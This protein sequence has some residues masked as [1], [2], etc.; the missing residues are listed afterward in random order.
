M[1]GVRRRR[2][3]L[4]AGVASAALVLAATGSAMAASPSPSPTSPRPAPSSSP[5]PAAASPVIAPV[6][7]P[8]SHVLPATTGQVV[9]SPPPDTAAL[10]AA[11]LRALGVTAVGSAVG[12]SVLDVATGKPL[13][14]QAASTALLPASTL[15]VLTAVAVLRGWG[16]QARVRT[17]VVAGAKGQIVLVG[18]GDAT[19]SRTAKPTWPAGMD[20]RPASLTELADATAKAL[21]A[22]GLATVSVAVDDSYFTGP[23]SAPGWPTAYTASG[24]IAPVTALS[25][26]QGRSGPAVGASARVKDPALAAGTTFADLLKARGIKVTG[27]LVRTKAGP[28]AHELAA[29]QSPPMSDLVERMLT[30]S[31]D[32]LAEAL[33]HLAGAKLGGSASFEGGSK[34]AIAVLAELG[35]PAT[36]VV[37]ADGSG[38]S[39]QDRLTSTSLVRLLAAVSTSGQTQPALWSTLTG[40][41]IA[42]VNGTLVDRFSLPADALGRGVV[43]AKTGTLTG[44]NCLT[45]VVRASDGRLLAFAFLGNKSPGP[46]AIARAA[47]DRA[48]TAV[49]TG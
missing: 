45:G 38:L 27:A 10:S 40:L 9:A 44:V 41:A 2:V 25:V 35:V 48:A 49:V 42:R 37:V 3:S 43:R 36:G 11:V 20:A 5:P 1:R 34:A 18:A 24:T 28:S 4:A 8:P 12:I 39:L 21:R 16:P 17:T 23:R 30:Q 6:P 14:E 31:D 33:G 26:D 29:V 32:D 13:V 47:L 46:Q 22:T 7:S 15:K 19:L